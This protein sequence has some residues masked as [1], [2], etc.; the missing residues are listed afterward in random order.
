MAVLEKKGVQKFMGLKPFTANRVINSPSGN[1]SFE[2][3]IVNCKLALV[4]LS[5]SL[6]RNLT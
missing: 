1:S 4:L 3:N 5:K 2:K 6:V